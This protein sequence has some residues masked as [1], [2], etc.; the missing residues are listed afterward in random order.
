M[1]TLGLSIAREERLDI[2]T[3]SGEY[4]EALLACDEGGIIDA[5]TEEP[6]ARGSSAFERRREIGELVLTISGVN[7]SSL[8]PEQIPELHNAPGFHDFQ[9][10]LRRAAAAIEPTN[11]PRAYDEQLR[12]EAADIVAAW[13]QTRFDLKAELKAALP[14]PIKATG[15]AV[16][17][18]L[19]AAAGASPIVIGASVGVG[20]A[21][22]RVQAGVK[23]YRG[24]RQFLSQVIERQDS[25]L[26]LQFP[27][28]LR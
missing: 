1:T 22:T 15:V 13:Q 27:L 6:E 11:D 24:K 28:G 20:L 17:T 18:G 25:A 3:D 10:A 9:N 8:R 16:V 14:E 5:L 7:L 23:A 4:H 12:S 21:V 2:I 26:Q 19:L